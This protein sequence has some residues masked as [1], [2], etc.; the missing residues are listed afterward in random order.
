MGTDFKSVPVAST[1]RNLAL[2]VVSQQ[3]VNSGL[4]PSPLRLEP[5]QHVFINA[6]SHWLFCWNAKFC[7]P[8]E[9]INQLKQKALDR[10]TGFTQRQR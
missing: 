6:Q 8:K 2:H 9:I 4:I 7:I 1:L 3:L 10:H 5:N